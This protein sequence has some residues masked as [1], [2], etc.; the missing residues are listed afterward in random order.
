MTED[1]PFLAPLFLGPA[2]ENAELLENLVVEFLRDHAFWRRNFHPEDGQRIPPLGTND[3]EFRDFVAR[4]KRELY[5]LSADLKRAVPFFHP[6]YIGHMT[7]DLLLPGVVARILTTLYNPNNVSEEGASVT[8]GMELEAGLQLARM[9]GYA[10]DEDAEPCAWGHLTSGGTTANYEALWNLRSVR[11]YPVALQAA[12]GE[13]ELDFDDLGPVEGSF[14]AASPWELTNLTVDQVVELRRA[15]VERL[16]ATGDPGLL[17]RFAKAVGAERI[18][19]R[20]TAGFFLRH[21]ELRPP[22]VLVPASAHYSWEKGMKVLGL[23]TENL[24]MVDVDDHMRMVTAD[25]DAKLRRAYADRT[26]VLCVVAVLGTT[27]SGNVDPVHE[28]VALRDRHRAEGHEFG[29]HID[30]AW[31]GYLVTMFRRPD[32]SFED[33]ETMRGEYRYFPSES[34]HAAFEAVRHADSI[35]VDPHKLGY[36]P[37]SAGAFIARNREVVN[38]I[39]QKAA[40]VFDVEDGGRS[41]SDRLRGLGQFILEGSKPGA[42]AAAVYVTHKTLPLDRTGFGRLL[43]HTIRTSEEFWDRAR[44]AR[45]R[46][47]ERVHLC[48][49]FEPD[50]NLVCLAL[51]PVGNRSLAVMNRFGRRLFGAMKVDPTRPLQVKTF[52]G[53]YTSLAAETTGREQAQRVLDELSIDPDTF[54]TLPEDADRE[55][56]HIFVLRHTL[57]NPWLLSSV[58]GRSYVDLY[59]EYLEAL[60]DRALAEG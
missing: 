2:A 55:A 50:T 11:F 36:V 40:Y 27:E 23:G 16:R 33:R 10:V 7:A 48:I 46:W 15:L 3:P 30:A 14:R 58:D 41:L 34:V 22:V 53:S 20:G 57:M 45:E 12:L 9:F 21:P 60:I 32:G 54:R 56:D 52:I 18:E 37:Y 28:V 51:N 26:P 19:A 39:T 59:W 13:L 47:A 38:F 35:T 6:R 8:V 44:Q 24:V 42:A 25:L 31:G 17:H 5:K 43:R 49:P 1:D 29:L 4:T